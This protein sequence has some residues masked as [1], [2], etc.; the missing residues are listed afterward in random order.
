MKEKRFLNY[1]LRN[2]LRKFDKLNSQNV[3]KTV[4]NMTKC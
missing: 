1:N 3:G 4:G 2:G